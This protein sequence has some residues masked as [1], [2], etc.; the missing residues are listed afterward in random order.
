MGFGPKKQRRSNPDAPQLKIASYTKLNAR[1]ETAHNSNYAS[2]EQEVMPDSHATFKYLS[3]ELDALPHTFIQGLYSRLL[4]SSSNI[5][6]DMLF[7]MFLAFTLPP[8]NT[9]YSPSRA[10][11]VLTVAA[12]LGYEPAQSVVPIAYKC[13]GLEPQLQ[14]NELITEWLQSAVATGSTL[15]KPELEKLDLP[16]LC[17]AVSEF[18]N[19]GGYNRFYCTIGP[20]FSDRSPPRNR[21]ARGINSQ[22]SHI[23]W[24]AIYETLPA[25]LDYFNTHNELE[26]DALT[27]NH[28]TPLYLACARGSWEVA[29]ELLRHSACPSIRC[30][31]F[32]ISCMHW[33]FAFDEEFQAEAVNKLKCGGADLNPL[34]SQEVPFLHYPF[35]L[36]AGTP[37]HWAVAT[38]SHTAVRALVKHGA[39]LLI[40]D[41]SDPYLYDGRVRR[42]TRYEG[43]NME[44]YQISEFKTEGLSPLD[45]AAMQHDPFIF[46][47]LLS[48]NCEVNINAV[49]EEGFSVLHRLSTSHVRRTRTGNAFS[50]LPFRSSRTQMRDDL[51]RT[52]L[53]IKALGADV[54]LQTTPFASTAHKR[55]P[56]PSNTPLMLAVMNSATDVVR[57]LLE[58]GACVH[59]E[60]DQKETAL[61]YL[62]DDGPEDETAYLEFLHLLVSHGADINQRSKSG[63]TVILRAAKNG[64]VA[65]VE[66]CLSKG[67][68]IGEREQSPHTSNEG[69]NVFHY[70]AR[71]R[72]LYPPNKDL[73]VARLLERY[74]FA[75]PDLEKK[76]RVI[77]LGNAEGET[78]LHRFAS[79]GM[80]HCVESLACHGAPINALQQKYTRRHEGG[81]QFKMSWDETPLDA[82]MRAKDSWRESMERHRQYSKQEDEAFM[83]YH[84]AVVTILRR[85]GGVL[86]PKEVVRKPFVFD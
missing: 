8:P 65:A 57:A 70:L 5:P 36:P 46:E 32:E 15:A 56:Q 81:V 49:D 30:T 43:P 71:G 74:V 26:V 86:A 79:A 27:N 73:T 3:W 23:H 58:A 78:I 22:Y 25:L 38:L 39:H 13:F 54:E 7:A 69:D 85:A 75:C 34:T 14:V 63:V 55:A 20:S 37:L 33:V 47:L 17:V 60:N 59:T 19:K 61:L 68:D 2:E 31:T 10:L 67:A 41:G 50:N 18:K 12:R 21:S 66:F 77:E 35:L 76:R 29:A 40:R 42:L 16:A 83:Q 62:P 45:L 48:L 53:A 28:E 80:P 24:L 52:V 1:S 6:G 82:A 4:D 51:R 64:I 72:R 11:D 44:A 84:E 9:M